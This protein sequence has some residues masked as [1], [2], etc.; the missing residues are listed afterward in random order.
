[1]GVEF[2]GVVR[3]LPN[4]SVKQNSPASPAKGTSP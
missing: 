1:M 4:L 2:M 3:K